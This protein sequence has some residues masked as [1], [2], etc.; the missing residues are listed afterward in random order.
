MSKVF[1]AYCKFG[2]GSELERN[3]DGTWTFLGALYELQKTALR[4]RIQCAAPVPSPARA[5]E[6]LPPAHSSAPQPET[7]TPRPRHLS[8][9]NPGPGCRECIPCTEYKG[10]KPNW[11]SF[12]SSLQRQVHVP[13]GLRLS[14]HALP[15]PNTHRQA[16][17]SVCC[18]LS[19]VRLLS[20]CRP[21]VRSAQVD[22]LGDTPTAIPAA[23]VTVTLTF[24][25]LAA[26]AGKLRIAVT[27]EACISGHS[28][29]PA[30][31]ACLQLGLHSSLPN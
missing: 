28:R 19:A 17:K 2:P 29:P 15:L 11:D 25:R 24:P 22:V 12:E 23:F 9:Q 27:G 13:S 31:P 30:C 5:N 1:C 10:G 7:P 14:R 26:A 16:P 8:L 20:V 4:Y 3:L 6:P 21:T 18:L